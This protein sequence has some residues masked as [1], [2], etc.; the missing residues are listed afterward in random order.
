MALAGV[1]AYSLMPMMSANASLLEATL[2]PNGFSL[3]NV[4]VVAVLE[5][6]LSN[7]TDI[8]LVR[9]A[10]STAS[11][12]TLMPLWGKWKRNRKTWHRLPHAVSFL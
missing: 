2:R 6:N 5:A 12:D 1:L 11:M 9:P 7:R 8:E 4:M 3:S 10:R